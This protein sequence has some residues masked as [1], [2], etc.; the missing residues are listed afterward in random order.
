[1]YL[2]TDVLLLTDVFEAFREHYELDPT[3]YLTL[4]AFSRDALLKST[5]VEL[6]PL[7]DPEM[8]M[9]VESRV[10]GG[11]YSGIHHSH[12]EANNPYCGDSCYDPSKTTSYISYLDAN[13]LYGD[14][15]C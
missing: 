1:M 7:T 10:R 4:P 2:C 13:N 14:A 5:K 11:G 8:H 6:E 3:H 9:F 15:M 12:A